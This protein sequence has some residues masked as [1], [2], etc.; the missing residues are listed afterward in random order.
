MTIRYRLVDAALFAAFLT[1][2]AIAIIPAIKF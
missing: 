2:A 1:N